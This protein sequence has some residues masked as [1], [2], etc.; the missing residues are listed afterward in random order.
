MKERGELCLR[1]W[2]QGIGGRINE[3]GKTEVEGGLNKFKLALRVM[4]SWTCLQETEVLG[5]RSMVRLLLQSE[6]PGEARDFHAV[7]EMKTKGQRK[8]AFQV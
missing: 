2:T 3:S 8:K 5:A 6:G 1:V 4:W 7:Q